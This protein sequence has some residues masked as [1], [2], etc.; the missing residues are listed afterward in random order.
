MKK[1]YV[2]IVT[3]CL[4]S[5]ILVLAY[6]QFKVRGKAHRERPAAVGRFSNP[7]APAPETAANASA[8]DIDV[9]IRATVKSRGSITGDKLIDA[10]LTPML[11][12]RPGWLVT[13]RVDEC[14]RGRLDRRE[15]VVLCSHSPAIELGVVRVGQQIVLR[16]RRSTDPVTV[17]TFSRE[18]VSE[19]PNVSG[20][21][22][23]VSRAEYP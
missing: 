5:A 13:L 14:L 21:K 22:Y 16:V 20:V 11:T 3:A 9:I 19:I 17:Y 1:I 12:L 8:N 4:G 23:I 15:L 7:D 2:V 6:L 18:R 10:T